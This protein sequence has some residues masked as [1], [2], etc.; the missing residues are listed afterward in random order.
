MMTEAEDLKDVPDP[1][2]APASP[3]ARTIAL[4]GL[5]GAGNY[6]RPYSPARMEGWSMLELGWVNVD[7]LK[8]TGTITM[9]PVAVNM[10][11]HSAR[12]SSAV[13]TAD[14]IEYGY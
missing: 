5:M 13:L 1:G 3:L 2:A 4:V 10:Q 14:G 8:T 12:R 7:T 9:N 11:C 6:A